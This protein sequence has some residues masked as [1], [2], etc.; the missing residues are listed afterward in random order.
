MMRKKSRRS[1][2]RSGRNSSLDDFLRLVKTL[3]RECPWDR[4]QTMRSFRNNA[5][6]EAHEF[7][8]AVESGK[9]EK[10]IE[11]LGDFLFVALFAAL[12][13]EQERGIKISSMISAAIEK[14]QNKHPHVFKQHDLKTA[15]AVLAFWQ[16]SKP[17]IFEGMPRSLPSMH[18]ARIIQERAAKLGFDWPGSAGPLSKIREELGEL[19]A[20]AGGRRTFEE[21]GDMLFACV[22]YARHVKIDPEHALRRANRKFIKRF[23][24]VIAELRKQDKEPHSVS[25]S[26]MDRIWNEIKAS[27]RSRRKN[28]R[29]DR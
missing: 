6:E 22:N 13:G 2:S 27:G 4:K 20:S 10:I 25:L 28:K 17:D 21:F 8:E 11:E 5:I 24:G 29:R 26:E 7:A 18:A 3:R 14:Y 9:K 1:I 12:I 15:D 19:K 23:R 16:K